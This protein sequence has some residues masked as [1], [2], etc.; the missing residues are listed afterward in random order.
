MGKRVTT[1]STEEETRKMA[2]ERKD[3]ERLEEV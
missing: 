3:K 1:E 2:N